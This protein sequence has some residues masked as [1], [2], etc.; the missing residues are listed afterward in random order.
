MLDWLKSIFGG[1]SAAPQEETVA[2]QAAEYYAAAQAAA[3]SDATDAI[4]QLAFA[5]ELDDSYRVRATGD[6][7]FDGLRHD[8]RYLLVVT[9]PPQQP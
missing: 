9:R 8:S 7:A 1:K 2:S 5:A 4:R 3:D 6:P